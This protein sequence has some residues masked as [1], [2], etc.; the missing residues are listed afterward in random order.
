MVK[1]TSR[2]RP[3]KPRSRDLDRKF[4]IYVDPQGNPSIVEV[5]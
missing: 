4:K 1:K 5:D 3:K 2:K